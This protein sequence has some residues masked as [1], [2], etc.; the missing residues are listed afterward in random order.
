M[1]K[2]FKSLRYNELTKIA[3]FLNYLFYMGKV[4]G[5]FFICL[6]NS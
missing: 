4:F 3:I 5:L 2:S 6:T 1:L